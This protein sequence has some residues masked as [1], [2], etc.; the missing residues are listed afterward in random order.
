MR[1]LSLVALALAAATPAMADDTMAELKTGGL[2][3]VRN[4][5]VS[6]DEEDLFISLDQVRVDYVFRNT[7]D[8][9]V[10][11]IVAFPMPDIHG[12]PYENVA[13]PD[14]G[15]DNFL[16]FAVEVD[17]KPMQPQ[18]QQRAFA[19][20]ID[21][22]GTL[23]EAGV[24]VNP[25][26]PDAKDAIAKLP[27]ATKDD[28][29]ARGMLF[30]DR[31]DAGKGWVE[32]YVPFWRLKSTFWW[33]MNFPAGRPVH[34]QHTYRPS[35]GATVQVSFLEDGKPQGEIHD[36]YVRKYCIEGAFEQA[37]LRSAKT[38]AGGYPPYWESWISFVLTTGANWAANIGH[39]HL[40]VDKGDPKNL[41]SFCGDNVKKTGP[42]TFEM[43][44]DDYYPTRDLD[45][46]FL[47]PMD[48]Q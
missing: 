22:T 35:V 15:S 46:L 18:L 13:V 44:I 6:M 41:V 20:D 8:A 42:T 5:V 27:Q 19:A 34:V 3:F 14:P 25:Y 33:R 23:Q 10:D 2:I 16:D 1:Y 7:S 11:A 48:S 32:E 31:Y 26:A 38:G 12:D 4:D 40:T 28:W 37:V 21:V 45:I 9:G 39:F 17:G 43:T 29:V 30:L 47:R 36:E 24:P